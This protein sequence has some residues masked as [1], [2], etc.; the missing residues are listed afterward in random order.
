MEME[1][2]NGGFCS[3]F[4]PDFN[5]V[6][7]S[8]DF[9]PKDKLFIY[10]DCTARLR[11]HCVNGADCIYLGMSEDAS[12]AGG[13]SL[14]YEVVVINPFLDMQRPRPPYAIGDFERE[15]ALPVLFGGKRRDGTGPCEE[16]SGKRLV[17]REGQGFE[18]KVF[19]INNFGGTRLKPILPGYKVVLKYAGDNATVECFDIRD[20]S[21]ASA[22]RKGENKVYDPILEVLTA[23][24]VRVWSVMWHEKCRMSDGKKK[25][26]FVWVETEGLVVGGLLVDPS[27]LADEDCDDDD[28]TQRPGV[29]AA[30]NIQLPPGS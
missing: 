2:V 12:R 10:Q 3:K 26:I 9:L 13:K 17:G 29:F 14:E 21:G 1:D 22:L 16:P 11:V 25:W 30:E 20:T 18:E 24:G 7:Q 8:F 27:S 19:K 5:P 23:G 4:P 28:P 15:G 6:D